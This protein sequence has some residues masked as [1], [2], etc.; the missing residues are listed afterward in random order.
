MSEEI[1]PRNDENVLVAD[2]EDSLVSPDG[3]SADAP[4]AVL[5]QPDDDGADDEQSLPD[6]ATMAAQPDELDEGVVAMPEEVDAVE[7]GHAEEAA[8]SDQEELVEVVP[9]EHEDVPSV[10]L[11]RHRKQARIQAEAE[12]VPPYLQ[13]T[14][15]VDD[16]DSSHAADES[17]A[18]HAAVTLDIVV[19]APADEA[20]ECDWRHDWPRNELVIFGRLDPN[21]S[22]APTVDGVSRI[23]GMVE[24]IEIDDE[25]GESGI[26]AKVPVQI[27]PIAHGFE[28]LSRDLRRPRGQLQRMEPVPVE[29]RGASK[30][31]QDKDARYANTRWSMLFGLE[32]S[33][34]RRV[35]RNSQHYGR[36]RGTGIVR[37][38]S[39]FDVGIESY[40]R[41]TLSVATAQHKAHLRG[42]SSTTNEVDVLV[43]TEH[44][45]AQRFRHGGQRL[46]VEAEVYSRTSVLREAHPDLEGLDDEIKERLRI[47]RE[48]L[49]LATMGEFPDAAAE[50]DF[51]RWVKAGSQGIEGRPGRRSVPGRR[52]QP[53]RRMAATPSESA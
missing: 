10:P 21:V 20:S 30:R 27:L 26:V 24:I 44:E 49:L 43:R 2:G 19:E 34:V 41:V 39:P 47:L 40:L 17:D 28:T 6:T 13:Q 33:L 29:L 32:V 46:L 1:G 51:V 18:A 37:A 48:G 16:A 7:H 52:Q 8:S 11:R 50:E 53:V 23:R 42:A 15:S 31:L 9:G 38:V 4:I 14:P 3:G 5:I 36:W 22:R 12:P 25:S 35:E 45:H